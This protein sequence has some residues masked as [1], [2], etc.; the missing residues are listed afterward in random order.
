MA[1]EALDLG[2]EPGLWEVLIEDSDRVLGIHGGDQV[3]AGLLDGAHVPGR[4]VP[5]SSD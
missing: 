5:G 1:I 2:E 4:D 3:I